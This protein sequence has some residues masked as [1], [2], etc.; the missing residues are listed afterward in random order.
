MNHSLLLHG[1]GRWRQTRRALLAVAAG[2]A[3][4]A[5]GAS[6]A[7]SRDDDDE[8]RDQGYC[9]ATARLMRSA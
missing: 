6:T 1:A 7:T 9:S 4:F 3:L 2:I 8:P 5:A